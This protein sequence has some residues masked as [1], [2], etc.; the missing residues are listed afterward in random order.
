VPQCPSHLLLKEK[1]PTVEVVSGN[2]EQPKAHFECLSV[3]H[4]YFLKKKS[5][6]LKWLV[7]TPNNQQ[8]T[9][10]SALRVPQ[11]PSH[12]LLKEKEPTVEVVSVNTQQPTPNNQQPKAKRPNTQQPKAKRP[13]NQKQQHERH[14]RSNL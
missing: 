1:E 8:P 12:S 7:S 6:R 5:L 3:L 13:N 2:T 9:T 4:I 14:A 10:K 11:C